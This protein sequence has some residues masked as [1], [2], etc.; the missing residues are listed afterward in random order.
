MMRSILLVSCLVASSASA[1]EPLAHRW[2]YLRKNLQVDAQVAEA[3]AILRRA[4]AAGYTAVVLADFKLGVLDRVIDRYFRN[5]ARLRALADALDLELIPAVAPFGYSS[6]ILMHDADL[7]EGVPAR[8]VRFEVRGGRGVPVRDERLAAVP[9]DFED[10]TGDTFRGWRFQDD[11]G[12]GT[13]ADTSVVHGGRTSL[14]VENRPGVRGVNRRVAARLAVHPW[15]QYHASVWIRTDA[16]ETPETVRLFAIG[17]DPGRTLNYQDLGVQATQDWTQHHVI[18]NSLD[19][20]E[21]ML[22]AGVWGAGGGRLWMDD[23]VI[24][25]APLVNVVRR[26][27]CP[28]V[29]RCDDG[30]ELEEGVHV[31]P[32]R[33]ERMHELAHRGDFEVYHDPPAIEFLPAAALPD[34]AI[35]R[36]SFHHAVSIYSGQVAASLSEPE[37][38][39]WF[40]HQVEGVARIL[41]PRRWFLSHDEIRVA[42]WSAPEIAAGRT[43]GD[44]LAANVGRC[45]GIVRARQPEAGLCVWSD[46]FD[47]H[48]NARDAFYLVN[49]TLAGSWEGLPADL[50][51][52]N[53]NSGKPVESTRFFADRGHEQV[54]AGFY[55]GPV[56]AIRE[57]LRVSRDHAVVGVM[58]TTW[59]DDYRQLEAFAEAAWGR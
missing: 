39:A 18:I 15:H 27:G 22:Y 44:V 25:E 1:A 30:R 58:Y 45:A 16:F 28:L 6:A 51:V 21:I 2:V 7:A 55:D 53:W 12:A 31:R 46:M 24:D 4:R 8:D 40:E 10:H 17:G 43:A 13:F 19:A 48:H 37:V 50:L 47:P 57:W 11:P 59:R 54:L 5:L 20:E 26:P 52:I 42:N 36:A 38:F 34:G 14:R 23:L 9:G 49:G 29:V 35:V 56:D 3:E 33:D 32:V 41:A